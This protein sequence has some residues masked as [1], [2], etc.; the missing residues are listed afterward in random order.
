MGLNPVWRSSLVYTTLGTGWE[1]GA[2]I[3]Q[4]N[5]ARKGLVKSM[6][7]LEGI[8]PDSGA[9]LNEV[10]ISSYRHLYANSDGGVFLKKILKASRY[11]FNWKKSF[12]G[13]HYEKLRDVKRKY[14]PE[15]MFLIYKGVASDEWDAE[16]VCRVCFE[17]K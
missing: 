6:K 16:L 15:E 11:E 3:T 1:D 13:K 2:N 9:Y 14:D 10:C 5:E 17:D 12:F 8:A 7:I 4:I